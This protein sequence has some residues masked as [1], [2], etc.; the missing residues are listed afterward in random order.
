MSAHQ[1]QFKVTPKLDVTFREKQ[2]PSGKTS[3]GIFIGKEKQ[4]QWM[5]DEATARAA[6]ALVQ[7]NYRPCLHCMCHFVSAGAGN[8]L[9]PRCRRL[10]TGMI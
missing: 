1:Y 2:T 6:F 10:D 9:C 5:N 8:R 3:Y 7:K 4:G